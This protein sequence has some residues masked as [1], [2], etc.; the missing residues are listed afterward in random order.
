MPG[1]STTC[2]TICLLLAGA[3]GSLAEPLAA[4]P[5]GARGLAA[6]HPGEVGIAKD[7][8]VVFAHD[9]EGLATPADLRRHWDLVFH[10]E[11]IRLTCE[12]RDV[13]GGKTALALVFPRKDGDV[14]NGL[15]KRVVPER[16]LLFL[17]YYQKFDR[18]LDVK[19]AG[20]FHNGGSI[21]AHSRVDAP[22][23]G[24]RAAS[25]ETSEP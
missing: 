2:L 6:K 23:L 16:E 7:P 1:S 20:S 13:H 24:G 18:A 22:R 3:A 19:G 9:F 14:G 21:S 10:D 25:H 8:A 12:P 17:R 11:T 4:L 5:E 15:M